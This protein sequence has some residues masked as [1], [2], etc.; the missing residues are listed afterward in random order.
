MKW[1][2]FFK[3]SAVFA[4]G[5]LLVAMSSI[6][7]S[8]E[9]YYENQVAVLLYHHIS[10][11][12]TSTVTITPQAFRDQLEYLQHK[13]YHFIDMPAFQRYMKGEG[14]PSNAVLVTFDDSYKSIAEQAL[15][16]MQ[17]L[18]IPA[19]NFVITQ[20]LDGPFSSKL[21]SLNEEDVARMSAS[22]IDIECHSNRLH[23]KH[24][25]NAPFLT[26]RLSEEGRSESE[27]EYRGRIENDTK[28]CADRLGRVT[29]RT[30][31][32]YA[33][34]FGSFNQMAI[35]GIRKAGMEYGF[36][37]VPE[38]AT[39]ADNE[40][41]IP[42]INAGSPGITPQTLHNTIV[43]QAVD[44][45]KAADYVPLR[46]TFAELGGVVIR[47]DS[48]QVSLH[49]G[50]KRWILETGKG[51]VTSDGIDRR[52]GHP[53]IKKGM[54]LWIHLNDLEAI[55]GFEII[56]QPNKGRYGIRE[57]PMRLIHS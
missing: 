25:G 35:E 45:Y 54:K 28:V 43:R 36:T 39:R 26:T 55:T 19:V 22:G 23:R 27:E 57:T 6:A 16:V 12:D 51:I 52:L 33:Y 44:P 30:V 5:G 18:H 49:Y 13:G 15:P 11:T 14:V 31:N 38:V 46:D 50:D 32:A 56:Y 1:L 41:L 53:L 42:R 2:S 47:N 8:D 9:V 20:D 21:P 40:M 17:T 3:Q 24:D 37:V 29:G 4:M 48:G 7:Q 10:E 34:P